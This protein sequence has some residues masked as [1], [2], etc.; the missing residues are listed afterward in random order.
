M[1][2]TLRIFRPD[3]REKEPTM[4]TLSERLFRI[5]APN[6]RDYLVQLNLKA[7]QKTVKKGPQDDPRTFYE[8]LRAQAEKGP[9]FG[10]HTLRLVGKLSIEL[11]K[12]EVQWIANRLEKGGGRSLRIY[13]PRWTG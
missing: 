9:L 6:D 4:R 5:A 1:G 7:L 13:A 2:C 10:E 8:G 12:P 3:P 11:S